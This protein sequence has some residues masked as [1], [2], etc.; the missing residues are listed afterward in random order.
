M[1][2]VTNVVKTS[3]GKVERKK[4][5]GK[6]GCRRHANI[7]AYFSKVSHAVWIHLAR[8][9]WWAVVNK[10]VNIRVPYKGIS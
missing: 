6:P 9:Q 7:V 1:G 3:V 8:D 2:Q 4:F 5:I 10:V